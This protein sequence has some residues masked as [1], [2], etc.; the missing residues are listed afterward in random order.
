MRAPPEG[1]ATESRGWISCP[2]VTRP[3]SQRDPSPPRDAVGRDCG[4]EREQS[5]LI[6]PPR[7]VR[8]TCEVGISSSGIVMMFFESTTMSAYLP[9][10]SDPSSFSSN[11]ELALFSV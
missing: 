7:M 2:V 5:Y 11:D 3:A 8:S 4:Q 1:G 6:E 10:V 9:G